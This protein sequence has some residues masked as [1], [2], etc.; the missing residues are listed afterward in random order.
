[1]AAF[2]SHSKKTDGA[3]FKALR[4]G[5][6]GQGIKVWDPDSMGAGASLSDQLRD[7]IDSSDVCIFLATKNSIQSDWCMA[8]VGAFWGAG[9]AVIVYKA[10][11]DVDEALFPP[12][13]QGDIWRDDYDFLVRD[14]K[15]II[16]EAEERRKRE[17]A[18]RPRMVSEMTIAGLYDALMSLRSTSLDGLPLT[19]AMR[20]IHENIFYNLAD[21]ENMRPLIGRLVGH[22]QHIIE[23]LAGR[24]W[25]TPFRLAT[26]TGEWLG[27]ARKFT[28][29][30][31]DRVYSN[32]LLIL[33]DSERN[34][35]A[36]TTANTVVERG[37]KII[38]DGL[39]EN[40]EATALGAP[41]QLL[42]KG[43]A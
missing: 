11:P 1:M 36:A 12:Q 42:P 2:I 20:L 41:K 32:C 34:C 6:T 27:F 37:D 15:K 13:L 35:V 43:D 10:D 5:L 9:K 8:E 7:A 14:V 23:E 17:A 31:L 3:M 22:P 18:R 28:S 16:F 39:I 33:C 38:C 30:E 26:D 29:H 4:A 40:A 19:E 25:P 21:A 24:F